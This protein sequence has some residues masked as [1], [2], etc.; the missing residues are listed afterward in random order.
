MKYFTP[1]LISFL[2]V[3]LLTPLMRNLA[4]RYGKV[5]IPVVNRWHRQPTPILGGIA[6]FIAFWASQGLLNSHFRYLPVIFVGSFAVFVLGL[7]DDFLHIKPYSKLIGQ[8]IIACLMILFQIKFQIHPLMSI[9][10]TILWYLGLMNAF[11]LLDNMD[12]LAAGIACISSL[13]LAI[14]SFRWEG[15]T[16]TELSMGLAGSSLGFLIYNRHPA[17]IFMG[18]SGS[19]FLGF[20]LAVLALVGTWQTASGLVMTLAVPVL[21][22]S[23]PIFDTIFVTL[24]RLIHFRPISEGG[25]DHTSH[26]LVALG[27]SEAKAV[28]ILYG[29]SLISG[30]VTLLNGIFSKTTV[31]ILTILLAITF[32][33]F[34]MFLG[35]VKI[36]S[37]RLE[38]EWANSGK[39]GTI[40][41]ILLQHKRRI[42]E[43]VTD[44]ILIYLS[45]YLA[46][47]LK[48]EGI[49]QENIQILMFDSL[50][51]LIVCHLLTFF[52]FG[53]YSGVW[54]YVGLRDA[55][56]VVKA[57]SAGTLLSVFL[58]QMVFH[59]SIYIRF[60]FTLYWLIALVLVS[61]SRVAMRIFFEYITTSIPRQKRILIIGAGDAGE[62]LLRSIRNN[63]QLDYEPIGFLDDDQK[64]IGKRIH[65]VPVLGDRHI[66]SELVMKEKI[67]E[68]FVAI[69]SANLE[70]M[71]GILEKCQQ[72][73]VPYRFVESVFN[74]EKQTG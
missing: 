63:R 14:Y 49:I 44:F 20:M 1:F 11:N 15:I 48:Y 64:K 9:P 55:L 27:I 46:Y 24:T 32:L 29:I 4:L 45:Y 8:I 38:K 60:I 39:K 13:M 28:W 50:P 37:D 67:E 7:L 59:P 53:L 34:G 47:F 66:L 5:S 2:V 19:L 57:I 51:I 52:Y 40:F 71:K 61:G 70:Q 33:L 12:G 10:L 31:L 62:M 6:L 21:L 23:V 73:Q 22:F 43:V 16:I 72:S 30:A 69:P 42:A 25:R 41:E 36:Y 56:A 3:S 74:V 17:R 26:R 18:D 35:E 68:V 54:K 58:I 65:G